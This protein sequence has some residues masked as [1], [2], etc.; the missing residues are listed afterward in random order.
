MKELQVIKR[1]A[2]NKTLFSGKRHYSNL[3]TLFIPNS[4][5]VQFWEQLKFLD[6]TNLVKKCWI[7]HAVTSLIDNLTFA[8][9]T[10]AEEMPTAN[11]IPLPSTKKNP[12]QLLH[13]SFTN[14]ALWNNVTSVSPNQWRTETVANDIQRY[15]PVSGHT[16]KQ[17]YAR[18]GD[19]NLIRARIFSV[20]PLPRVRGEGTPRNMHCLSLETPAEPPLPW[21]LGFYF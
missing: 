5:I 17:T 2:Q 9:F 21:Q 14:D 4:Y 7:M 11:Q 16:L 18:W 15:F 10:M 6:T 3:Q 19:G 12:F 13:E 1:H 20:L 8:P